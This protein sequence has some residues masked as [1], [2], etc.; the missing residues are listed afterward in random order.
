MNYFLALRRRQ[1]LAGLVTTAAAAAASS[2]PIARAATPADPSAPIVENPAVFAHSVAS[3]DPLSRSVILW[4]RVTPTPEATPGSGIGDP[5]T[6]TWEVSPTTEFATIVASG[7]QSTDATRDLTVKVEATGLE[8]ATTYYYRFTVVDGPAAGA[9]SRTGRT[10][11]APD[12]NADPGSLRFAVCSCSNYEAGFF[13]TYRDI[14]QREDLE[15]VLHLGDFTYEYASGEYGGPYG[16]IAR[17]VAPANRTTTLAD[18]RI[19]QGHYHLD[20]DLANMLA[21]KPLIPMWD[22]HEFSDNAWSDGASGNSISRG[23]TSK[24]CARTPL[25]PTTSGCRCA[26]AQAS[27]LPMIKS[28][29]ATWP[30]E[31]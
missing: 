30:T 12:A 26:L 14:A 18:Y 3:G 23:M 11:T 20:V 31:P 8:P 4:T 2:T 7:T 28:S 17:I 22:D 16:S 27:N 13:N 1:F 15:F 21:A 29:T 5:T 19:R 6:V 9:R 25:R 10:R 24:P